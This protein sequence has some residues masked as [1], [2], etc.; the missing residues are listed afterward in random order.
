[1]REALVVI[2][3]GD[4]E[5]LLRVVLTDDVVVEEGLD[6]GGG[7]LRKLDLPLLTVMLLGDDVVGEFDALVADVDSRAG[8]ELPHLALGLAAERAAQ[9]DGVLLLHPSDLQGTALTDI[10]DSSTDPAARATLDAAA[11]LGP[12]SNISPEFRARQTPA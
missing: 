10:D 8:D 4:G 7:G 11:R 2:V 1:V 9:V 6:L 5:D 12:L 3:D